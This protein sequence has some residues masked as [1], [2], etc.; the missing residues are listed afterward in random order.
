VRRALPLLLVAAAALG[1][2]VSLRPVASLRTGPGLAPAARLLPT[3]AGE[4]YLELHGP[5]GGRPVVLIHGFGSSLHSWRKVAPALAAAGFRVLALDLP[6][7]GYSARPTAAAAYTTEAQAALVAEVLDLLAAELEWDLE[8]GPGAG[9]GARLDGGPGSGAVDLVGHSF[10]GGVALSLAAS[11]PERV[12]SLVLVDSTLPTHS[13][14]RRADLPFYRPLVYLLIRTVGLRR[15]F[16]RAA[17]ERSFHDDSL[18][19]RELVDAYRSRLLLRG[20]AGAYRSLTAPIPRVRLAVDLAAIARPALV[21]WGEEDAL[22][23]A[24]AG[25]RAAERLPDARFVAL[26]ACGHIPMEEC[27]EAF[28]EAALAFLAGLP[29]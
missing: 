17:L 16:V 3:S 20:P 21:V 4:V 14:A 8:R 2:C 24:R 26:P 29:R 13:R 9:A 23:P 28:L 11:R 27:P 6:G 12:R 18:V 19:T 1:G 22:I 25:R 10:G 5:E 15:A 7:F